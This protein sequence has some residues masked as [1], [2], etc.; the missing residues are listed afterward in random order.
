MKR[1]IVFFIMFA[2]L[3]CL[4]TGC[5]SGKTGASCAD[6][7]N[8]VKENAESGF[9]TVYTYADEKY[10]DNF[11]FMYGIMWDMIDDGGILYTD[12][13]GLADEV[14]IFHL[15]EQ[16]DISIAKEKLNDRIAERRNQFA[17][18]KPEEVYK[19]DNAVIMVQGNY[20]A[21]IIAE[22]PAMIEAS[23]RGAISEE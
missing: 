15:K 19:L 4:F 20:V 11:N 1:L 14:S 12:G 21:L 7:L 2:M 13:G 16:S 23:I 8:S 22:D 6:I 18:Y 9:D 10:Q 17:G 5:G 3:F